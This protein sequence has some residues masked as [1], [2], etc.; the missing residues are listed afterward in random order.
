MMDSKERVEN[1]NYGARQAINTVATIGDLFLQ[2]MY[3]TNGGQLPFNIINISAA[4]M[5]DPKILFTKVPTD[6]GIP[7]SVLNEDGVITD[8]DCNDYVIATTLG[9]YSLE[10]Y[11]GTYSVSYK[12]I[13]LDGT[14]LADR[15]KG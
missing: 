3:E 10:N 6:F 14:P 9:V 4:I 12:K 1:K 11:D 15:M 7:F 13:I 5:K 2:K 8:I